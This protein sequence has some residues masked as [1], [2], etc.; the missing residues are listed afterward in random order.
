MGTSVTTCSGGRC[1]LKG[2]CKRHSEYNSFFGESETNV[3]F[4]NPFDNG[5]CE[6]FIYEDNGNR[7]D[8]KIADSSHE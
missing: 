2:K 3:F 4:K 7:L 8:E 6:K 1:T 5:K